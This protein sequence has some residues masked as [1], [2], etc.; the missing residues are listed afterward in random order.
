MM[1]EL[2]YVD[3]DKVRSLLA[4]RDGGI[5]EDQKVT[6]K[7][8]GTLSGGMRNVANREQVWGTEESTQ[9]SLADAV[10]PM[11]EEALDS[12]GYLT[13]VSEELRS[14]DSDSFDDF[15]SAYPPGSFVRLTGPARF[16]DARYVAQAFAG[17]GVAAD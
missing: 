7:K 17:V 15:K 8:Q 9:R 16:F 12:E 6:E 5:T 13:D 4:Q 1:R 3:T 14:F 2:I 11:L 10:F